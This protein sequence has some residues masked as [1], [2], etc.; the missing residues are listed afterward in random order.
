IGGMSNGTE[1]AI[2]EIL[3]TAT[4]GSVFLLRFHG[5]GAPGNAG[6]SDG[7]GDITDVG[8][9]LTTK[10]VDRY[11]A[12]LARLK[13]IFGPY[14]C[15]QLMHCET[16]AGHTGRLLLTKLAKYIGVPVTAAILD[17]LGGGGV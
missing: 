3:R 12:S 1:Q 8:S 11:A 15:V 10:G 16:G 2:S 9:S 4:P 6:I 5:H 13:S 7:T 14:G 17:Q